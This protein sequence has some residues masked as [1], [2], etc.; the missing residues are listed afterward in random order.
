M[1]TAARAGYFDAVH[2]VRIVLVKGDAVGTRAVKTRPAAARVKFGARIKQDLAA[3][4][5]DVFAFVGDVE[6]LA[7]K[8]RFS[9]FVE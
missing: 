2:A 7:R 1:A 9:S 8:R 5:A 3:V 4:S 6:Q